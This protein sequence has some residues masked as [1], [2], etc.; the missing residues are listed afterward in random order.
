MISTALYREPTLYRHTALLGDPYGIGFGVVFGS[1]QG[2]SLLS[3]FCNDL[4]L[5]MVSRDFIS[6][7]A[8]AVEV[9]REYRLERHL[10][11]G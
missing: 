1:A 9:S 4:Y 7:G 5:S 3:Y 2:S 8:W 6:F 11:F 10:L